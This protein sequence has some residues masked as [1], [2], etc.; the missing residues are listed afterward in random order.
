M[1]LCDLISGSTTWSYLNAKTFTDLKEGIQ[2]MLENLEEVFWAFVCFALPSRSGEKAIDLSK[3][4]ANAITA[5]ERNIPFWRGLY[6][7]CCRQ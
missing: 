6:I 1:P 4:K 7:S 5:A 3:L 2:L